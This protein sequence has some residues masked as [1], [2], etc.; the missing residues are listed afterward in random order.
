MMDVTLIGMFE[1]GWPENE[2]MWLGYQQ[3]SRFFPTPVLLKAL[4]H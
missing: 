4:L 1:V 3:L 2:G